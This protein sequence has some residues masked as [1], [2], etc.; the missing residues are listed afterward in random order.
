MLV[1]S[2]F[3]CQGQ[4][5]LSDPI[6]YNRVESSVSD[7]YRNLYIKS[8][9]KKRYN[10]E[11]ACIDFIKLIKSKG[12]GTDYYSRSSRAISRVTFYTIFNEGKYYYFAIVCFRR[13][14]LNTCKEYIYQVNSETESFYSAFYNESAGKTFY[15]YIEPFS[16]ILSC[17][18]KFK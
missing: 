12:T 17:S 10:S 3:Y 8:N 14:E 1:L 4:N 7:I 9:Y 13:K 18:P 15:K 2:M 5:Y 11:N 16:K 6:K